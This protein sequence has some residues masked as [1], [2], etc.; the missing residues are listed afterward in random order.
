MGHIYAHP[1]LL[2]CYEVAEPISAWLQEGKKSLG[3]RDVRLRLDAICVLLTGT[4]MAEAHFQ[5]ERGTTVQAV[6]GQVF[7]KELSSRSLIHRLFVV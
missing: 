6:L 5:N 2:R 1:E 7:A 4:C 3:K